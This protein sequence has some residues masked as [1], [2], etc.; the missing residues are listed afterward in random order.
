MTGVGKQQMTLPSATL[1]LNRDTEV[2]KV[3]TILLL[4]SH[5]IKGQGLG[6]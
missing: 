1:A 6:M 3:H 2:V 4:L 5:F